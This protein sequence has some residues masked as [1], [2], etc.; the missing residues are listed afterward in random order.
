MEAPSGGAALRWSDEFARALEATP[1]APPA[2]PLWQR[3]TTG[4]SAVTQHAALMLLLLAVGTVLLL[5][6]LR[7]PFVLTFEYDQRRPWRGGVHV[8]WLGVSCVTA[9]VLLVPVAAHLAWPG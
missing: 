7:P 2:P 4:C 8:S 6:V 1:P 3:V 9:F 5:L